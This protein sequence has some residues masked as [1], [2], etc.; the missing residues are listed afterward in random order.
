MAV[1]SR[2]PLAR[3]GWD[4]AKIS[5]YSGNRSQSVVCRAMF[6]STL[7][8]SPCISPKRCGEVHGNVHEPESASEPGVALVEEDPNA[9]EVDDCVR[10]VRENGDQGAAE[11]LVKHLYPMVSRILHNRL[12]PQVAV[13][14]VAQQ[15]F[16]KVFS[17][18]HQYRGE[19]PV[20]RWVARI[21]VNTCLNAMRGR[22]LRLEVR[23]SDLSE[24]EDA[25]LDDLR[26][27]D[28]G[29]DTASLVACRD[30][31]QTLLQCLSPKERLAVE[32]TELEGYTSQE[33]AALLGSNAVAV[34]VRVSR[35]RAKMRECLRALQA[36][37]KAK[38]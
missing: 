7:N 9:A 30:L 10:R 13:D 6:A 22:R 25:A 24:A 21:A 15:V 35:A 11:K 20:E 33:T 28:P 4:E 16:L 26:A 5:R 27:I 31:L 38:T 1:S 34:R 23:R 19:I 3:H 36:E 2:L 32:L 17:K 12:P 8:D 29:T 18:I 37:E 14:D